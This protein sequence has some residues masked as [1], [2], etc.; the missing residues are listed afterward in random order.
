MADQI[1]FVSPI[2]PA[3]LRIYSDDG[4]QIDHFFMEGYSPTLDENAGITGIGHVAAETKAGDSKLVSATKDK[5]LFNRNFTYLTGFNSDGDNTAPN[6]T[7]NLDDD[8]DLI[9]WDEDIQSLYIEIGLSDDLDASD[10]RVGI[11]WNLD[12]SGNGYDDYSVA[13][14]YYSSGTKID[15]YNVTDGTADTPTTQNIASGYHYSFRFKVD[16]LH[17]EGVTVDVWGQKSSDDTWIN[18]T[19]D[20]WDSEVASANGLGMFVDNLHDDWGIKYWYSWVDTEYGSEL[21][22]EDI[23]KLKIT[24]EPSVAQY[25]VVGEKGEES[26]N[27]PIGKYPPVPDSVGDV[28][29]VTK[30]L[31]TNTV[32]E[33]YARQLYDSDQ[34]YMVK[35][36]Y[37]VS[38]FTSNHY[39]LK[40][41]KQI[42]FSSEIGDLYI[43]DIQTTF[44]DH[45]VTSK[46][47]AGR[48]EKNIFTKIVEDQNKEEE[49]AQSKISAPIF[50]KHE[51]DTTVSDEAIDEPLINQGD[52]FFI[53]EDI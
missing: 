37:N 38:Y 51:I 25:I 31:P 35:F 21:D 27:L 48:L 53:K 28:K 22:T 30:K 45:G 1:R 36:D 16:Y 8:N 20:A 52:H 46:V 23:S 50:T 24:E 42:N 11:V 2:F 39:Y 14:L 34:T 13:E 5:F 44:Q 17:D 47:T 6:L 32:C 33:S 26:V 40:P 29:I 19:E 43:T 18:M 12:H 49:A 9:D 4:E 3:R 15:F 10:Q 41:N 7:D